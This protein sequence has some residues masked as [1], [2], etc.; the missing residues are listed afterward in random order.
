MCG[1]FT[2]TVSTRALKDRYD[3]P[4]GEGLLFEPQYNASPGMDLPV[5]LCGD[6]GPELVLAR[7]GV[8][9]RWSGTRTGM[10]INGRAETIFTK[11]A[12]RDM[13]RVR[14][15][16]IP[17]DGFYEWAAG[18]GGNPYR[19]VMKDRTVFSLAGLWEEVRDDKGGN[20]TRTFLII[21]TAA[22][23]TVKAV[24]D[25]MPCIIPV[26][27]EDLWLRNGLPSEDLTASFPGEKMEGYRVGSEVN[28]SGINNPGLIE[29]VA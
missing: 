4:G 10:L 25:R 17:V 2:I 11:P 20:V 16:I 29:P 28:R 27:R 9:P 19:F 22:N 26:A 21:T 3:I 15:C 24:H 6:N 23:D 14:R 13:V 1:R 7:W 12:F 8:V 5:I 18:K